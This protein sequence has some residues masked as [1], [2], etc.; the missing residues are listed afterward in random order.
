MHANPT[1]KIITDKTKKPN[2]DPLSF[3][4]FVF[5]LPP[6]DEGKQYYRG[7]VWSVATGAIMFVTAEYDAR[8]KVETLCQLWMTDLLN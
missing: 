3:R 8:D 2:R 1:A 7:E 6:T 4:H 5:A